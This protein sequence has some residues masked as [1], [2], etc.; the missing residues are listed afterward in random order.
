MHIKTSSCCASAKLK[1]CG[2]A[3]DASKNDPWGNIEKGTSL[4]TSKEAV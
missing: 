4:V 3:F 2:K 1:N